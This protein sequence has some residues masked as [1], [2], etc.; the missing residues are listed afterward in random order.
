MAESLALRPATVTEPRSKRGNSGQ[1]PSKSNPTII[2]KSISQSV[3]Q[4]KIKRTKTLWLFWFPVALCIATAFVR[5]NKRVVFG[6]RIFNASTESGPAVDNDQFTVF[7][8]LQWTAIDICQE[9]KKIVMILIA[10]ES[11]NNALRLQVGDSSLQRPL[12]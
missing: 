9:N 4:S 12:I 2:I 5:S 8:A 7:N 10:N 1:R 3:K 11:Y 6:A